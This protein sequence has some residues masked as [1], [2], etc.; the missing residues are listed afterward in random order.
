MDKRLL[1]PFLLPLVACEKEITVELPRTDPRIVVEGTIETGAP[2][3]ILLSRTQNFFDPTNVAAIA[4]TFVSEAT[5]TVFDG[6][7]THTLDRICSDIIPE[8][9]LEEV[10]ALVGLDPDL[11]RQANI[12]AWTKIDNS[13]VGQEGRTY[14][15]NV[16][17]DGN[18]LSATTT[19][20]NA[21]ALDSLWFRLAEQN[22]GDDSLGFMWATLSDPDTIGNAYRWF[23]RRINRDANGEVKDSRF[24]PPSFSVFEDRFVNGLTFDF[25]YN[26]GSEPFSTGDDPERGFFKRG[27]TVV[28]KL[29]SMG[30]IE[31][32]FYNTLETNINTQGDVFSNPANVISN[33]TGGLGVWAGLGVRLDTAVCIP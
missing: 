28:V 22:P 15:L 10:A 30:T 17:A 3:I 20:P 33:V 14:T 25:A 7:T 27:D 11:L 6:T 13:L 9:Q 5:V 12:C 4:A 2:P 21:V 29:A 19:I 24:I 23:A 1:L 26:R 31:Y 32:R 8:D 16:L 18:E